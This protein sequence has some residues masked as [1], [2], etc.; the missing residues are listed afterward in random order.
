VTAVAPPATRRVATSF[1]L[2]GLCNTAIDFGLFALLHTS[3]GITRANLVSTAAGMTFSFI[4][5]GLVTFK[6]EKLTVRQL[7]TFLA[8]TGTV[9]LVI[10]PI[11]I[12]L[13]ANAL[14]G[15]FPVDRELAGKAC[16]IGLVLVLNFLSYRF[17]VWPRAKTPDPL[18]TE[19]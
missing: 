8:S 19:E 15:T 2:V 9:L 4:V 17:L 3:L 16:S 6:A 10:Q 18:A 7:I 12:H 13:V 11:A 1:V 5:N 14:P